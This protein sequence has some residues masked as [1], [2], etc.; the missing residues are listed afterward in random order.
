MI[1][2]AAHQAVVQGQERDGEGLSVD[3][4]EIAEGISEGI[5]VLHALSA[6]VRSTAKRVSIRRRPSTPRSYPPVGRRPLTQRLRLAIT[7]AAIANPCAAPANRVARWAGT[8]NPMRHDRRCA[9]DF[10]RRRRSGTALARLRDHEHPPERPHLR[11]LPH[12]R[13]H[14]ADAEGQGAPHERARWRQSRHGPL[15]R[16]PRLHHAARREDHHGLPLRLM[17]ARASVRRNHP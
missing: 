16:R 8:A 1:I 7:T 11:R 12:A 15:Q 9:R 4:R 5:N 17:L 2:S 14:S 3:A 13:S 6:N 10:G